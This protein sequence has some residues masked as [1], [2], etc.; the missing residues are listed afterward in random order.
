LI[1]TILAEITGGGLLMRR[2]TCSMGVSLDGYIVGPDGGFD[3]TSPDEEGAVSLRARRACAPG[4][5]APASAHP[6]S[7]GRRPPERCSPR[8]L[9]SRR[10][11]VGRQGYRAGLAMPERRDVRLRSSDRAKKTA[12]SA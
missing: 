4:W 3:W 2:V 11:N 9:G 12:T 10:L 7:T 5:A 1:T 6:A 8:L